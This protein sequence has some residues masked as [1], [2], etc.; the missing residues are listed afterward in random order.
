MS[1]TKL[2]RLTLL[3]PKVSK[4]KMSRSKL[5]ENLFV[6]EQNCWEQN[7]SDQ[8]CKNKIARTKCRITHFVYRVDYTLESPKVFVVDSLLHFGEFCNGISDSCKRVHSISWPE[9]TK[10]KYI[11]LFSRKKLVSSFR[12]KNWCRTRMAK[13]FYFVVGDWWLLKQTFLGIF[14]STHPLARVTSHSSLFSAEKS[15][16]GEKISHH[17]V[18]AKKFTDIKNH[19]FNPILW[20]E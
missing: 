9:N 11:R 17:V 12:W 7:C 18:A 14:S 4:T 16:L 6:W 13:R 5:T 8:K 15:F 2:S 10:K 20:S 1:R 19:Q 3:G